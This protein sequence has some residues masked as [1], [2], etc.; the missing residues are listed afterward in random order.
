MCEA[1]HSAC[2]SLLTGTY[3]PAMASAGHPGP[4]LINPL[5]APRQ[6]FRAERYTDAPAC[7]HTAHLLFSAMHF[8]E[9]V[10]TCQNEKE[11]KWFQMLYF[12]WS[13]SNDIM[14]VK[15]LKTRVCNHAHTSAFTVC[16]QDSWHSL[17]VHP[18]NLCL[19]VT[20]FITYKLYLKSMV[21]ETCA[22]GL[23]KRQ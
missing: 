21:N 20:K 2:H 5:T 23:C 19:S 12:H 13:F 8:A 16:L 17:R 6:N 14:V 3:A 15:G 7:T 1:A 11:N 10:L 18:N 9:N 22:L 4:G